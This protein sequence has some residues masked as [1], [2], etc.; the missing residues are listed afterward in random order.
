MRAK[1]NP[2]RAADACHNRDLGPK[3]PR[4]RVNPPGGSGKIW[5]RTAEPTA[6]GNRRRS[7]P[8]LPVA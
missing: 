3:G 8:P 2:Q 1:F 4:A 5:G 7:P 6:P